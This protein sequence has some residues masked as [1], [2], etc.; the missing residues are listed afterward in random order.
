VSNS[1]PFEERLQRL[2]AASEHPI[3][4]QFAGQSELFD[5]NSY[6]RFS[7][8]IAN[9]GDTVS[10][11]PKLLSW[12]MR[13]IEEIYD[14]RFA[15]EAAEVGRGESDFVAEQVSNL[16][17]AFVVKRLSTKVGLRSLVDQ[18]CWDLLYNSHVYRRDYLEVEMFCRFLQV[19]DP[20]PLLL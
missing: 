15:H 13:A 16:F 12:L 6:P 20:P 19:L 4:V 14:A 1:L 17:P 5:Y 8:L 11:R 3:A 7:V 2:Q 9:Q 10:P 18:T